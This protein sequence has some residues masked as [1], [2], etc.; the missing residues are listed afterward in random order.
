M[1]SATPQ[2]QPSIFRPILFGFI[3][4]FIFAQVIPVQLNI[5]QRKSPDELPYIQ[6]P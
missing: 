6:R 1:K 2:P 3:L 4:G 5:Q